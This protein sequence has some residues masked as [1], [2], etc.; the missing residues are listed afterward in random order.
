MTG[1]EQLLAPPAVSDAAA[2]AVGQTGA[3][4][5][6]A[7]PAR[8]VDPSWPSTCDDRSAVL[9][10]VLAEPFRLENPDSQQ[11]RR[12]GVLAVLGWL[13]AF[14]GESWQQRWQASG[15]EA[16]GDWRDLFNGEATGRWR[17]GAGS[18]S[19][20]L[21]VGLLVLICA[22]VIR[23]GL[24]WLLR[25]PPARRALATEMART[26]DSKSFAI[27][28]QAC[29]E[30][31]VGLQTRQHALTRIAVI[32]A[33][34]GGQV[35][36]VR[37]GDCVELLATVTGTDA[38]SQTNARSPLFYQ[39]LRQHGVLGEDA[40]AAIEMFSGNGQPTCEQLIDRYK[41]NCWPVRD[42]LVD[43]LRERQMAM[44]FSSLQRTAYLLGKL[45]WADLEAHQP[46]IDSLKFSSEVAASWKKRVMT[47]ARTSTSP[48]GEQIRR[49]S[50]RLDG[51]SVFSAVRAFYLDL[52]E[53]ADDDPARWGRG[54]CV[55][56]SAPPMSPTKKTGWPE[57][58]ARTNAPANGCRCCRHWSHGCRPNGHARVNC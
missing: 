2:P 37:V 34:K 15:A 14:P 38:G 3:Q 13:S 35:A 33:A 27:L 21:G 57:N 20:H 25:F 5:M 48:S 55:A 45:F 39:L 41:I 44:D 58:H 8:G 42:V 17:T 51:R 9:A 53:W 29:I 12:A 7:F 22:D 11:T 56:R 54:R 50:A 19:P 52:A 24:D 26:R 6:A 49:T 16:A 36:A 1:S 18:S 28:N 43:Y 31:H 10:R 30:G 23:P 40:P 46:G 4:L 47:R 32:M